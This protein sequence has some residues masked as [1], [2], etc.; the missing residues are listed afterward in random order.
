MSELSTLELLPNEILIECLKCLNAFEIFYSF[1]QLN[2]RFS[3]LIRNIFLYLNFQN[4]E[5]N[6]FDQFCQILKFNSQLKKQIYSLRLSNQNTCG[7]IDCFLSF[8]SLNEFSHLR[9]L[10]LI[11]IE[12][13]N[14]DKLKLILP[15]MFRLHAFHLYHSKY[16]ILNIL[17]L[18]N[19]RI[20]S[21]PSFQPSVKT[22]MIITHLTV[23]DCSMEELLYQ[24]FKYAPL[25]KYLHVKNISLNLNSIETSD[26]YS[27]VH[28]KR[29]IIENFEYSFK[30]FELFIKLIPNLKSLTIFSLNNISMIDAYQWKY[31]IKTSLIYLKKFQFTFGL[32]CRGKKRDDMVEKFQQFQTDFWSKEHQ[33]LIEYVLDSNSA[34]IYTVPYISNIYRLTL[35]THQMID[36]IHRFDNV[37]DLT[38]SYEILKNKYS[39][40]FSNITSLKLETTGVNLKEDENYEYIQSLKTL[41][42]FYNL[43]HLDISSYFTIETCLLREIFKQALQLSSI[44]INPS[45]LSVLFDDYILCNYLNKMIKKLNI[46]KFGQNSFNSLNEMKQFC[47]IFANIEQLICN[48]NQPEQLLI[49]LNQS[50]RLSS[51]TIFLTPSDKSEELLSWFKIEALKFNLIYRINHCHAYVNGPSELFKTELC[52]WTDGRTIS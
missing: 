23:T 15:S 8:F 36:N 7:Q 40:Y 51:I 25:L 38:L 13:N 1:N 2:Y 18:S 45:I 30:E 14:I 10:T 5:K 19:L 44:T 39:Y 37:K 50:R 49:L 43:K 17:P 3:Q 4:V 9:S 46:Y 47:E 26:F 27:A 12:E 31:L 32:F 28:L 42:N 24:I 16:D 35:C 11:H 41:V 29:L 48:I 21:I 52:I 6:F 22:S 33:C 20:L 34:V